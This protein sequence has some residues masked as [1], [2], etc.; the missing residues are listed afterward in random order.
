MSECFCT[1]FYIS[2]HNYKNGG[3]VIGIYE[4]DELNNTNLNMYYFESD[5]VGNAV[6]EVMENIFTFF[7][8]NNTDRYIICIY[9]DLK[10]YNSFMNPL[11]DLGKH[12]NTLR[13]NI[14]S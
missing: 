2:T 11:I 12:Q 1:M 10:L 3:T 14:L 7:Y 5:F 8:K 9:S 6:L 13:E 4:I